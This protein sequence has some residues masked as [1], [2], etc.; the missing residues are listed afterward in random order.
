MS[1]PAVIE[2]KI[3]IGIHKKIK[4]GAWKIDAILY[5]DIS[6]NCGDTVREYLGWQKHDSMWCHLRN[7]QI[8]TNQLIMSTKNLYNR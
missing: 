2:Y 1:Y 8:I 3:D 6:L 7:E 4:T 5:R